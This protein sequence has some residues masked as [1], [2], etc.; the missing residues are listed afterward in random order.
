MA[1]LNRNYLLN[2]N[3]Q[4]RDKTE[5]SSRPS[6]YFSYSCPKCGEPKSHSTVSKNKLSQPTNSTK[7]KCQSC[8]TLIR[9]E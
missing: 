1:I 2:R 8:G 9:G 6:L 4:K 5:H 7:L 3:K